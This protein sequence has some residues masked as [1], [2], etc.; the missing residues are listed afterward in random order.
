MVKINKYD[1]E[2]GEIVK[3]RVNLYD[4]VSLVA[5]DMPKEFVEPRDLDTTEKDS[6]NIAEKLP[7]YPLNL[8]LFKKDHL[9][10][11]KKLNSMVLSETTLQ[12]AVLYLIQ[13]NFTN[14]NMKFYV[15]TMDNTK[16]YKQII[17]PPLSFFEA[18]RYLQ[19]TYGLYN[20][21]LAIF[22]DFKCGYIMDQTK[23]VDDPK[24]P[25]VTA[26][27]VIIELHTI[28][29]API[30]SYSSSN[31]T[32]YDEENNVYIVRCSNPPKITRPANSFNEM[33][34]E[35]VKIGSTNSSEKR[36]LNC[37]DMTFGLASKNDDRRTKDSVLINPY[38]NRMLESEYAATLALNKMTIEL[39]FHGGDL[40]VFTLNRQY[41]II[42][43]TG[44][45]Y[46]KDINGI[47]K[48]IDARI[49]IN[50][51]P[52][53]GKASAAIVATFKKISV[54]H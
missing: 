24:D 4:G 35:A 5:V 12:N 14:T 33:Y 51:V 37:V 52:G 23:F 17:I 6:K 9:F 15:G 2:D 1:P 27:K 25:K 34:G 53:D 22:F 13:K 20:N 8:F 54:T 10:F 16:Q 31:L 30:S 48:I 45:Q 21:G 29:N 40:E 32:Y 28:K 44:G 49:L 3:Q 11:N 38:S 50:Q 36:V 47:F 42:D 19:K 46:G 41:E 43:K 18:V 7:Q 26:T 39:N